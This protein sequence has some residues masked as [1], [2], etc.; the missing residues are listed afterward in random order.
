VSSSGT[1]RLELAGEL[2]DLLFR[3]FVQVIQPEHSE[4]GQEAHQPIES[5]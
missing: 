1:T 3:G 5:A 2:L 4:G